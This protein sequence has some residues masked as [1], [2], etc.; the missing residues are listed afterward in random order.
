MKYFENL[1]H[2]NLI[3]S[4]VVA[5]TILGIGIYVNS[6]SRSN[7]NK[8][9]DS[10]NPGQYSA[11]ST[12]TDVTVRDSDGDGLLDWEE[13]LNGSDP[14]NAD[15]DGDGTSD[16]KEVA[17]GRDPLKK[18]PDDQMPIIQDPSFATSSTDLTGIKKEFFAKYLATQSKDIR[19]NTYRDLIAGFSPKKFTVTN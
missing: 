8:Q 17:A 7:I 1:Q 16:G 5:L 13:R 14:F 11:N 9:D 6:G 15:T 18:G 3:I 12:S 4:G 19:E 2:K 10:T